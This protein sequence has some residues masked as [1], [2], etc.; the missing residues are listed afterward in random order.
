[1]QT[2]VNQTQ[3]YWLSISSTYLILIITAVLAFFSSGGTAH[4]LKQTIY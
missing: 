3:M 4:T 2:L 1:M